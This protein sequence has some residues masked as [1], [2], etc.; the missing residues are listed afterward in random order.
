[1]TAILLPN[2]KKQSKFEFSYNKKYCLVQIQKEYLLALFFFLCSSVMGFCLFT[3]ATKRN[4]YGN[5]ATAVT[6]AFA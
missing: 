2:L 3:A 5:D 1:M 4:D 6:A